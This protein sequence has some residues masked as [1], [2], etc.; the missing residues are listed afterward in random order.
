VTTEAKSC[1]PANDTN[2]DFDNVLETIELLL[3]YSKKS[4]INKGKKGKSTECYTAC[5]EDLLKKINALYEVQVYSP[6]KVAKGFLSENHVL[7]DRSNKA[8]KYFLKKYRF[9]NKEK[10]EEIHAAKKYFAQGGIP[11]ILPILNNENATYFFFEEGYF[12]LFPF[13]DGRHIDRDNLTETAAISLGETLAKIHLLGK[14]STLPMKDY[15]KG[16]NK[17]KFIAKADELAA[18]IHEKSELDEF[19][20]NALKSIE[21]RK[22]LI[23]AN[24]FTFEDLHIPSDCL[25]HGDYHDANIFFDTEDN[26]EYVFDFEKVQYAPRVYELIRS[27]MY[28]FFDSAF[29]M[30]HLELGKLYIE[31]YSTMYPISKEELR[32]GLKLFYLRQVHGFWVEGEHYINHNYRVDQFLI[33]G[34]NSVKYL[35]EHFDELEKA[36]FD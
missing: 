27:L 32:A 28:M 16:W 25:I 34:Y 12:A 13:I 19:D 23:E 17:E 9:D 15:F 22:S 2:I 4:H 14:E 6:E 30:Q 7:T 20:T 26:V 24:T 1:I 36:L 11:V 35:T 10:I 29:S 5:M 33:S 18:L 8:N 21:M 3:H 31:S